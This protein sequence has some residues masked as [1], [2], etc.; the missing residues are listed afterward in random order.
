[1]SMSK[2]RREVVALALLA[3]AVAGCD[4]GGHNEA[5]PQA[6]PIGKPVGLTITSYNYTNRYIDQFFVNGAG[7]GNVFVS[8]ESSGGG[9]GTCCV[10]YTP[11]LPPPKTVRVRWQASGCLYYYKGSDGTP[12]SRT[13][14]Y[15]KEAD[16]AVDPHVPAHPANFEVH[17]Y[18][19]GHVEA[20][21]TESMS[22]PRLKLPASREDRSDYPDCPGGKKPES[23]VHVESPR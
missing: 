10:M 8:T 20:A 9:K 12:F 17:F 11:G 22:E 16:A 19:D 18:P 2:P 13:H 14:S 21:I 1:M 7:G 23:N 6:V 15:F 4:A 5:A 3:L